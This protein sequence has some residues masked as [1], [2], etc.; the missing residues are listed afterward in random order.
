[1][2]QE[3][4]DVV[5]EGERIRLSAGR[6]NTKIA[7]VDVE[8]FPGEISEATAVTFAVQ[9]DVLAGMTERV[10]LAASSDSNR[11]AL[12]GVLLTLVSG[13]APGSELA[14]TA[15]DGYRLA[16]EWQDVPWGG[17]VSVIVPAST[18]SEVLALL[19]TV[20]DKAPIGIEAGQRGIAF[21]VPAVRA[22]IHSALIDAKFPQYEGIVPKSQSDPVRVKRDELAHAVRV[23][24]L[25]ADDRQKPRIVLQRSGGE[26]AVSCV[27]AEMG[28]SAS[29]VECA[30]SG[31]TGPIAV[32]AD[33]LLDALAVL[34]GETVDIALGPN[35]KPVVF[36]G[37]N[38]RYT[39]LAMPME[40][41]R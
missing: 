21:D 8:Q 41:S 40:M 25:F 32:N 27:N 2:G 31:W 23:A 10:V 6:T 16:R 33:Y 36:S 13:D 29:R 17:N 38:K 19:K 26:L 35:N 18:M 4:I 3:K 22:R 9:R 28:D 39:H 11:P 24:K 5:N 1:V 14:M 37:Q 20:D 15:T 30:D 12:S 34:A 7:T